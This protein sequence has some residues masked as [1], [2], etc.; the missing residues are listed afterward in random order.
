[1]KDDVFDEEGQDGEDDVKQIKTN[2]IIIIIIF[3]YI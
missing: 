2:F 1:M 3:F